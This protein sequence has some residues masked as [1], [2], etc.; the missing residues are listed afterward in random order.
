M[1]CFALLLKLILFALFWSMLDELNIFGEYVME[2][3][4]QFFLQSFETFS[5]KKTPK[6]P[7]VGPSPVQICQLS[8]S[9]KLSS[10][11]M[12]LY[13]LGVN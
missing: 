5:S 7:S 12:I 10:V 9:D 2:E 11:P 8:N 3:S 4:L 1:V 13:W 6:N